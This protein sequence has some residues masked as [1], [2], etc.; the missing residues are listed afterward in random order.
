MDKGEVEG[1]APSFDQPTRCTSET[2]APSSVMP[3]FSRS[4][5]AS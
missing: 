4:T 2:P 5:P 1:D 3:M